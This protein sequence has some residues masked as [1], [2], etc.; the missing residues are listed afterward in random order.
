M[1]E[2]SF[3]WS[4]GSVLRLPLKL[5]PKDTRLPILTGALRG[6]W[7]IS[8]SGTHGC[9]IGSYESETQRVFASTVRA[10]DTVFDIGANVGFFTLL[11]ATLV[12]AS[13]RVIAFEPLPRNISF[14]TR[15]LAINGV[16]NTTLIEAAVSDRPGRAFLEVATNPSM[17]TLA[18]RG[19][20]V[21]VVALDDLMEKGL[22]PLPDVMKIDVEGAESRVLLGART[23]LR[24]ARPTLILSTH[25]SSQHDL[26]WKFLEELGFQ[27]TLRRDGSED[28]MYEVLARHPNRSRERGDT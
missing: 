11:S 23:L 10:G 13:G 6:K 1:S 22:L 15:N 24:T 3:R 18:E 21:E 8:T 19:L 26:C 14:L 27:V 9:W 25:G 12:G 2:S 7:W 28:G 20:P 16:A 4:L 5:V 17:G